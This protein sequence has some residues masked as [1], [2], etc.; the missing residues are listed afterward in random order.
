LDVEFENV[1]DEVVIE[2]GSRYIFYYNI[3][4]NG[5][6]VITGTTKGIDENG[7]EYTSSWRYYNNL[8]WQ[9]RITNIAAGNH[10]IT[11]VYSGDDTYNAANKTFNLVVLPKI[12]PSTL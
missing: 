6:N 4:S 7:N 3:I 9:A 12:T 11:I 2:Y 10:T 1:P 5:V 8:G